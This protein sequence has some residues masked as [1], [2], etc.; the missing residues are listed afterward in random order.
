MEAPSSTSFAIKNFWFWLFGI[1][2]LHTFFITFEA[3]ASELAK[4]KA[5]AVIEAQIEA[6][7]IDDWPKAYSYASSDIRKRFGSP[8][9]FKEMVLKGY[10]IVY[11]PH[12]VSFQGVENFGVA[13]GFVFHMIG[14]DGQAARVVYLMIEDENEGWRIAGVRLFNIKGKII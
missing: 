7:A 1:L 12:S 13:P 6:M 10:K 11:R 8:Q 4:D 5:K 2:V 14:T 9:R 3:A